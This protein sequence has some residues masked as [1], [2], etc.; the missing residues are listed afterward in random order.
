MP[1]PA[2][3]TSSR[4]LGARAGAAT[5]LVTP[6]T[7]ARDGFFAP[8]GACVDPADGSLW[9]ADSGHHRVL[10]WQQVPHGPGVPADVLLGQETDDGEARNAGDR[11]PRPLGLNLPVGICRTGTGLAVAD[12]WNHRVLLWDTAPASDR[13]P[14]DRVLGQVDSGHCE[15]NRGA[16]HPDADT[17]Y[18][19]YGVTWDG[20]H[21]WVCDS[22]NRRVLA[23]EGL[24]VRDGQPA[25][26]VLGQADFRC[27]D[28]NGGHDPD[29]GSMRWPHAACRWGDRLLIADAGNHRVMG[30]NRLPT[31]NGAPA[32]ELLG[33]ADEHGV[34]NNGGALGPGPAT[35]SMPYALAV[36][37]GRLWVADTANSRLL[38]WSEKQFATGAPASALFGQDS[39]QER[40]ENR[41]RL[42]AGPDTLCW[43]YGL[44][45][46]GSQLVVADSGNHRVLLLPGECLPGAS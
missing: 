9:V 40:G 21:L 14:P 11:L 24:P 5:T 38:A 33:Q 42:A 30:W 20:S 36:L 35:L 37:D 39:Y 25:D 3:A 27:R 16:D 7:A 32:D 34:H 26:L 22:G 31:R 2:P 15:I 1:E 46:D 8:R 29:A 23:W 6:L 17:L 44:Q 28:E 19:P 41:W 45:S 4:A 10:G 12:T 18:W 43:P 13:T